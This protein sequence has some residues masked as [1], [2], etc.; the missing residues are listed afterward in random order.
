MTLQ[1]IR[2]FLWFGSNAEAAAN[3][4]VSIF[5]NS[6]I[7]N[8]MASP[9]PGVAMGVEFEI[10][11]QQIIAF[12]GG[13]HYSLTE[14]VSLMVRCTTQAEVDMYWD[15]LT[16]DGGQ[17]SRCGWLKDRFGLSWQIIPEALPRLMG[18]PDRVRAQRV[19]QAMLTMSKID[20]AM[21][22]KAYDGE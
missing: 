13:P 10:E 4:Y 8:V 11:G 16:A 9:Q 5:A 2:P 7:L 21:L 20:I 6:K 1:K 14:A 22:Q 12:N 15:K 19:V 17:P 18:D 3:L